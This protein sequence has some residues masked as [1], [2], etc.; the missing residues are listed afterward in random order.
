MHSTASG[1]SEEPIKVAVMDT[2]SGRLGGYNLNGP[3]EC[4]FY[5]GHLLLRAPIRC[6]KRTSCVDATANF[7]V[8]FEKPFFALAAH[9]PSTYIHL[10]VHL[11]LVGVVV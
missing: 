11:R 4:T 7:A 2:R 1:D 6:V 3:L 5:T 8:A 9:M 10:H